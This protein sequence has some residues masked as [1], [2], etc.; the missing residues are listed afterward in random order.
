MK[1]SAYL[2]SGLILTFSLASCGTPSVSSSVSSG[3]GS[4]AGTSTSIAGTSSSVTGTPSQSNASEGSGS[5]VSSETSTVPQI[6]SDSSSSAATSLPSIDYIKVFCETSWSYT[7]AWTTT[8]GTTELVG[9]W[10]G[11]LLES[12]N[13]KWKTYDFKGYTSLNIIFNKG[14]GA[15]QTSDL[16]IDSAGYWWYYGTTWYQSEPA[17]NP[18]TSSSSNSQSS[19]SSTSS[20]S[21]GQSSVNTSSSVASS[22]PTEWY[23]KWNIDE[24]SEAAN[25]LPATPANA[26]TYNDFKLWNEYPS[27]YWSITSPYTGT[28]KDFRDEQIY[29]TITSRFYNGDLTN[30]AKCWDQ[31]ASTDY[32]DPPW[33]GDFKG[34]IEK[35]DYIKA[36]GF[37]AIWITPVVEN[38]SGLDYHGYHASNLNKVDPRYESE[39]VDFQ[40]VINEAHKRDMKIVLDVVWNHTG[41]FGEMGLCPMFSKKG[42][43]S[44]FSCEQ[45]RANSGLPSNYDSLAAG[46]QYDARLAM[47]KNTDGVNHDVNYYYHHYGNFS[48]ETWG[49]QMAQIAGDCVDLNTENPVVAEYLLR[50]YGQFIKMGVDA[51]RVDTMKQISR[52]TLNKFFI[53][54]FKKF[55]TKC[56]NP[57][58]FMFGE[59]CARC[60]EPWNHGVP[61]VSA[62]FYTWAESKDYTFGTSVEA[63]IAA[64]ETAFNDAADT[65]AQ[66]TSTNAF[67]NGV[68]YHTPDYSKASGTSVIDFPMHWAFCNATHAFQNCA[69]VDKY[70]NDCTYNV[71]YVNSHDYSPNGRCDMMP[72]YSEATWCEDFDLMY[73]FRGIPCMYY[74]TEV[75]F[76]AGKVIDQGGNSA[77]S[78]TGRAYFGD[79]LTGSLTTTGFGSYSGASGTIANTL[80]STISQHLMKLSKIRQAVPALRYGQYTTSGC[81][82]TMAFIKRYTSGTTDS[83]AAVA[84]SSASTFSA[85]PNGTYVDLVSGK[86]QVVSNGTLSVTGLSQAQMAVYVL[87]NASSGTLA[88]IGGSTTYLG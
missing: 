26:A 40:K 24:T 19:Q 68:T 2:F 23:N 35:M 1:K 45:V 66:P 15:A 61:A 49:E 48:W 28:R 30:D 65:N 25:A 27:S 6:S 85:L 32:Y 20:S 22:H 56:G 63:N 47:M 10:P 41:N 42:D 7:Y 43:L 53:G 46:K 64:T 87:Q 70:F 12:Y 52:L 76:Q 88:K 9:K 8:N 69:N 36:L 5:A 86:S 82:G 78:N 18:G 77:L 16:S 83:V 33:R 81:S 79:N 58:F 17:V 59:V 55:A 3:N 60:E 31:N 72:D 37:T 73:T 71:V 29:F 21:S 75:R 57:N 39:D 84:I 67:L 4:S 54:A 74:G 50:C 11:A 34:L 80:N 44:Y 38:T 14:S 13:D 51:F 62:P